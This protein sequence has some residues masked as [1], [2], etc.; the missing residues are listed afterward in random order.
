MGRESGWV[1]GWREQ[2]GPLPKAP[3][4]YVL[5]PF[6]LPHRCA[7]AHGY[8]V[9]EWSPGESCGV[10]LWQRSLIHLVSLKYR[11]CTG[12]RFSKSQSPQRYPI[13]LRLTEP[14]ECKAPLIVASG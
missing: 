11:V 2:T 1:I 3:D 14:R 4:V 5:R 13:V 8:G 12:T 7:R 9:I 10:D 6:T